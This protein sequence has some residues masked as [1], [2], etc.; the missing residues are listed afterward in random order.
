MPCA[1]ISRSWIPRISVASSRSAALLAASLILAGAAG[2]QAPA[3]VAG[4]I[5]RPVP[6]DTI[7]A[8]GVRVVLHR[9]GQDAQG[10]LDSARTGTGGRF[11][12]TTRRD[13]SA[14]FLVSARYRG[15]EF[16]SQPFSFRDSVPPAP[17]TLMVSDTSSSAPVSVG[18]RYLVI[19]APDTERRRTAV[20]LFVLRNDGHLTRVAPDSLTPTWRA[21]LPPATGHRVAEVGSEILPSAVR[22]QGDTVL[23]FAPLSPGEKQLLLEHAIPAERPDWAVPLGEGAG[24]LQVVS[25]ED[26]V[27]V[28]GSGLQ[29]AEAQVVDGRSLRR[30]A[31]RAEPGTVLAVTFPAPAA[32]EA[33][34][35]VGLVVGALMALAL[36]AWLGLRRRPGRGSG[37]AGLLLLWGTSAC[38]G[39]SEAGALRLVDDAGDT[40]ALARPAVRVVS[41][42]PAATELLYA[43]GA[44]PVLVGRTDWCDHPSEAA[45][46]PS[47]G[48]GLEPNIEAVVA[49]RPDLV[50][51][52]PSPST[53]VAAARLRSL[54]IPAMQWR[55]DRIE[56]LRRGAVHLGTLTGQ[57]EGARTVVARLD[58]ALAAATRTRAVRPRVLIL[59]WDQPPIAIGRASFLSELVQRAGG[60]NVFDDLAEASGPVGLEAIVSRD[61]DLILAMEEIPDFASRPQ[62]QAVRAV[63][64]RRFL[65]VQGTDLL[66]P[67]PR[68]GSAVLRLAAALD[69]LGFR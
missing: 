36:F 45:A 7:P 44:G 29:A 12:F 10:P 68:A 28:R 63:R 66:R 60:D 21:V 31:G 11:Q 25:E 58:S 26:G 57:V 4:R 54:G 39:P 20:D 19:G 46:V 48:A 65:V 53:A 3:T 17:V 33:Q 67:T 61:P 8:S 52:Y 32:S 18:G 30:W 5:V 51:L 42:I 34:L 16:F 43:I 47:V 15:I 37:L 22:F 14:I 56:D 41:L 69:S 55:T 50:L 2:A 6:G 13:S 38:G 23:V 64:E 9:V 27:A 40:V 1:A 35:V 59:A 62:W 24:A 49:T